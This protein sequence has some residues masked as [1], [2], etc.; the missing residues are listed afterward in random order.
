VNVHTTDQQNLP[1]VATDGTG[2]FVVTWSSFDQDGSD[3]GIFAR[4]LAALGP[5]SIRGKKFLVKNLTGAEE[6][7]RVIALGRETATDIGPAI[8]GDPTVAGATLRVIATGNVDS[9]QTYVLDAGGWSAAGTTGFKYAGPT[10][11]D[12][13]PVKKVIIRRTSA[14]V[15]LLK[16]VLKG[17]GARTRSTS[18][19][20]TRATPLKSSSPST[21][22]ART[23]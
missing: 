21:A 16:A 19:R 4:R 5:S 18:Y 11:G 22:A 2:R 10:G 6:V 7:R 15:A 23:A 8:V 13:D 12:G 9:D 3:Y 14:G 17:N 1:D 20:R